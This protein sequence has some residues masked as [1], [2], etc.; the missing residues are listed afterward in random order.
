MKKKDLLKGYVHDENAHSLGMAYLGMRDLFSTTNDLAI[1]AQ[2]LLNDGVY[3]K[4]NMFDSSTVELFTSVV[5]ST[6]YQ[7]A[8]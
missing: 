5:D 1:F 2:M 7:S 8:V 3:D 4:V 6:C